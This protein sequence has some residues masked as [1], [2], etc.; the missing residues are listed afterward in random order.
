MLRNWLYCCCY[1]VTGVFHMLLLMYAVLLMRQCPP[2]CTTAGV[3][4]SFYCRRQLTGWCTP[5]YMSVWNMWIDLLGYGNGTYWLDFEHFE[6]GSGTRRLVSDKRPMFAPILFHR[7]TPFSAVSRHSDVKAFMGVSHLP[8][9]TYMPT[10][11]TSVELS[12]LFS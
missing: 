9:R 10:L 4:S 3:M 7:A 5:N 8:S 1:C 2:D 6:H 11:L 12:R